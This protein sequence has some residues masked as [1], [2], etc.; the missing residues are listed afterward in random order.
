MQK[1]SMSYRRTIVSISVSLVLLSVALLP[2]AAQP[3]SRMDFKN[4]PI[5]DILLVLA[6]ASGISIVADETISGNASFYFS[7]TD[8]RTALRSF[9]GAQ[10]IYMREEEGIIYVS[11]ID[12]SVSSDGRVS[13]HAE[14]VDP[15]LILKALSRKAGRTILNDALPKTTMT[16]HINE[17]ALEEAVRIVAARFPDYELIVSPSSLYLKRIDASG[18][19]PAS[20]RGSVP[21]ILKGEDGSFSIE[22]EQASFLEALDSL[23]VAEGREYVLMLRGDFSLGRMK[24]SKKTFEEA[25][26]LLLEQAGADYVERGDI[27]YLFEIQKKD[28]VKKL[29]DTVTLPV[30]YL[31][32]QDLVALL[33]QEL[34]NSAFFRVDKAT[35]SMILTGSEQE[36]RPLLDYIAKVDVPNADG[37]AYTPFK[38]RFIK[39]KDAIAMIP[40]RMFPLPPILGSDE[41]SFTALLTDDASMAISSILEMI[42]RRTASVPVRLKYI[43]TDELLKL[44]PPSVAK[45]EVLD[46]GYPGLLFFTGSEDKLRRFELELSAIDRP[47]PQIQYDILVLQSQ[48]GYSLNVDASGSV[49]GTA[50]DADLDAKAIVGAFKDLLSIHFDIISEFGYTFAAKLTAEIST[51]ASEVYADTKLTGVVGHDVKFQN[52]NT[53]RYRDSEIDPDD[54]KVKSTGV[55]RELTS[56]LLLS[57]NGWASSDGMITMTIST[58]VSERGETSSDS[59]APPQTSE[60][61]VSTQVRTQSGRPVAIT[62]LVQRNKSRSLKKIPLLGD[63]PILGWLFSVPTE[64]DTQTEFS[65]YIVPRLVSDISGMATEAGEV[66]AKMS[67]LYR[68]LAARP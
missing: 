2:V 38:L 21:S 40:S 64:S 68:S 31:P 19:K 13:V 41:Y 5:A 37:R 24:H 3:I 27:I 56:G 28:I 1:K 62:G 8:I 33:P 65:V 43:K 35:N 49:Q 59:T 23:M 63:I 66:G 32:V 48:S 51:S 42:D 30:V 7:E 11:R 9:L 29:R 54:G 52:T 6:E 14:D 12:V 25:L 57:I 26:T 55:T 34:S 61:V 15:S 53:F 18:K 16:V 45:D 60:R 17:I 4:Q 44:L 46:S 22:F 10:R 20:A 58:T 39:A 36:I 67:A 47:K 50:S